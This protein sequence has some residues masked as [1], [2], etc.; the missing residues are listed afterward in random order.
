M[1]RRGMFQE[2][3][4]SDVSQSDLAVTRSKA[5]IFHLWKVFSGVRP[6]AGHDRRS[7][8]NAIVVSPACQLGHFGRHFLSY[9]NMTVTPYWSYCLCMQSSSSSCELL[10]QH[11]YHIIVHVTI[12][13]LMHFN[14]YGRKY[15]RFSLKISHSACGRLDRR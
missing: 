15:W 1:Q 2:N 6:F 8:Y 3:V 4:K 14:E 13:N 12:F 9:C 7:V 5:C 10:C 11:S